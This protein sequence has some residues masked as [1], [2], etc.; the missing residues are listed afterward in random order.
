MVGLDVSQFEELVKRF[1]SMV[2]VTLN[3]PVVS[4]ILRLLL[5]KVAPGILTVPVKVGLA[6][7]ARVVRLLSVARVAPP[8]VAVPVKA[9]FA[10]GAN[11]DKLGMSVFK[12]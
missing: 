8:M 4:V 7:G 9:G 1:L 2:G 11:P 6:K 10:N 5:P 3:G 12:A